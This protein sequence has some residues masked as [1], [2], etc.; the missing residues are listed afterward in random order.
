MIYRL[1]NEFYRKP[2]YLLK[3][4]ILQSRVVNGLEIDLGELFAEV[5]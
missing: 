4:D 5:E 2:E 1:E 3:T